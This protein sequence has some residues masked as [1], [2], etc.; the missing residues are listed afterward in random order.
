MLK[1]IFIDSGKVINTYMVKKPPVIK[2]REKLKKYAAKEEFKNLVVQGWTI[3]ENLT[4]KRARA[5]NP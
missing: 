5:V 4:K 3:T 1:Y 2:A